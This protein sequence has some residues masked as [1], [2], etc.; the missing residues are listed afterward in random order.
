M[1]CSCQNL[2]ALLCGGWCRPSSWG[3]LRLQRGP[4]TAWPGLRPGEPA[5]RPEP[6]PLTTAFPHRAQEQ[7]P[8]GRQKAAWNCL[9]SGTAG[10]SHSLGGCK[11][12]LSAHPAT[13]G[14][15]P[16]TLQR[17]ALGTAGLGPQALTGSPGAPTLASAAVRPHSHRNARLGRTRLSRACRHHMHHSGTTLCEGGPAP[18]MRDT[19]LT[20]RC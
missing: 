12:L 4:E 8:R 14:K 18:H 19:L 2:H 5:V 20:R 3:L 6:C 11:T 10:W 16:P 7:E 1:A 9:S 15:H 13:T 17:L